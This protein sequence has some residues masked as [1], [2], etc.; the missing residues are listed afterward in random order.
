MAEGRL[1]ALSR[2][3][4][5]T[6]IDP[7]GLDELQLE[8]NAIQHPPG[9]LNRATTAL[10]KRATTQWQ[11]VIGE[12]RESAEAA[13][14]LAKGLARRQLSAEEREA[15]RAQML[16]LVRVVPAGII[17]MA[18]SVLPVPGTSMFTPWILARLGLM[19]SRWREAHL[20]DQLRKEAARLRAAGHLKA[21]EAVT[22][23]QHQ[24]EEE[25]DERAR[26]EQR[27]ELLTHWDANSNGVWD[28]EEL[29]AYQ[30]ALA[31]MQDKHHRFA[32]RRNWYLSLEDHVFGPICLSELPREA[33]SPGL[34]VCYNGQ[35]GWVALDDLLGG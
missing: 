26:A 22:D 13:R 21:A 7:G 14:L 11:H 24:L 18:N 15:V 25:A 17:T 5:D 3:L 32:A 28:D 33:F 4:A 35:S 31:A 34:L 20:L 29:L 19:P 8:L 1:T 16:D 10:R 6:G 2:Q 30:Q 12:L 9:M 27:A 23:L